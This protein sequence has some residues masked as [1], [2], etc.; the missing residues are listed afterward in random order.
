MNTNNPTKEELVYAEDYSDWSKNELC[1]LAADLTNEKNSQAARIAELERKCDCSL[2]TRLV[3]DGC[4][5]CNP[6]QTIEYLREQLA[7]AESTIDSHAA[8]IQR[9]MDLLAAAQLD[10]GLW[11]SRYDRLACAWDEADKAFAAAIT[12][13]ARE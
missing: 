6:A 8:T 5:K 12:G 9:Y 2:R 4:E 7:L 1:R 11:K 10:A 13:E 3:G